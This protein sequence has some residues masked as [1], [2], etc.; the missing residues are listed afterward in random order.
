[1]DVWTIELGL[2]GIWYVFKTAS[3][4]DTDSPLQK[5]QKSLCGR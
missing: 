3:R 5:K 2:F 1:M 4:S